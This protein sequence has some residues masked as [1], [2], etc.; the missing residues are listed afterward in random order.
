LKSSRRLDIAAW[1]ECESLREEANASKR[2]RHF[3][4]RSARKESKGLEHDGDTSR[5]L[6]GSRDKGL[7]LGRLYQAR[8]GNSVDLPDPIAQAARGF[9][10]AQA[11]G[12][13]DRTPEGSTVGRPC[14][15]LEF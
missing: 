4:E 2:L 13:V 11:N 9:L 7:V 10:L 12:D 15:V 6:S 8:D 5:P 3:R 14:N 1:L